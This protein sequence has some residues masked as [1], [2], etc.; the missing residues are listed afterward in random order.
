MCSTCVQ[1]GGHVKCHN[2][3]STTS[4]P[5]II[6][7]GLCFTSMLF[8][9]SSWETVIKKKNYEIKE[10]NAQRRAAIHRLHLPTQAF[11]P[12]CSSV[13]EP[14]C[15]SEIIHF[16]FSTCVWGI[17]FRIEDERKAAKLENWKILIGQWFLK[18]KH[19]STLNNTRFRLLGQDS[20]QINK[21]WLDRFSLL[22]YLPQLGSTVWSWAIFQAI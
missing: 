11:H 4:R 16:L 3:T 14:R 9:L 5:D 20:H 1:T 15:F 2:V 12:S 18:K 17:S 10:N 19:V 6:F 21:S 22:L 13:L 7:H 8:I